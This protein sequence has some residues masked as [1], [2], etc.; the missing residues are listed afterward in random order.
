MQDKGRKEAQVVKKKTQNNRQT[1]DTRAK[2]EGRGQRSVY[3][4][5]NLQFKTVTEQ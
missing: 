2:S 1:Q 3:S 5:P 4:Q